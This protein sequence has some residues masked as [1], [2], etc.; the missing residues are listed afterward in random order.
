MGFGME[1]SGLKAYLWLQS[2]MKSLRLMK[3]V[4]RLIKSQE[5]GGATI[6]H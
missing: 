2:A 3:G 4:L 6:F 5:K 1:A